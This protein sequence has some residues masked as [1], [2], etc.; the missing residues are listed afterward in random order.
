MHDSFGIDDIQLRTLFVPTTW[1]N[2]SLSANF[3]YKNSLLFVPYN[4]QTPNEQFSK[5]WVLKCRFFHQL[6]RNLVRTSQN[7]NVFS[8]DFGKQ[9]FNVS[10]MFAAPNSTC[11]ATIDFIQRILSN[12]ATSLLKSI[13]HLDRSRLQEV[14]TV[15]A[16]L[17]LMLVN[18]ELTNGLENRNIMSTNFTSRW[19]DVLNVPASSHRNV[20]RHH[21]STRTAQSQSGAQ[22]RNLFAVV[23]LPFSMATCLLVLPETFC[24]GP[25]AILASRKFEVRLNF[26]THEADVMRSARH[27]PSSNSPVHS[28]AA[29]GRPGAVGGETALFKLVL[30]IFEAR[31]GLTSC[32]PRSS[33]LRSFCQVHQM[34][35]SCVELDLLH[36]VLF[37]KWVLLVLHI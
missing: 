35:I 29:R 22:S 23:I 9:C 14:C 21:D 12:I 15:C 5:D 18:L 24:L 8:D 34:V 13:A 11:T 25:L 26:P 10:H 32:R 4:L 37:V 20:T 17:Y 30:H 28:T 31:W 27:V 33:P 3:S 16:Q 6:L 7:K 19:V 2:R 36:F 1:S